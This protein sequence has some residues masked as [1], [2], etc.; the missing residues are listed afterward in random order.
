VVELTA[1]FTQLM[2]MLWAC[3][4]AMVIPTLFGSQPI[5]ESL[6]QPA[7]QEERGGEK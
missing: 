1:S 4:G 7:R 6:S 3:F 5:Y 2:P